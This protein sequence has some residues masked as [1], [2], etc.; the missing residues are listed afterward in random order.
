[1]SPITAP[2][3]TTSLR[4]R[5]NSGTSGVGGS[6]R[7]RADVVTSS[8]ASGAHCAQR[9]RTRS[10]S[11]PVPREQPAYASVIGSSSN[12]SAVTTP[13]LPPPPRSAQNRSG[14]LRASTW[15][16][17]PSAVTRSAAVMRLA[18][19][20][21]AP[22]EEAQAAAERVPDDADV[23]G[24]AVQRREAVLRGG[25]DDG[26]P[27]DSGL[28]ARASR[29]RVDLD[30]VHLRR[31]QQHRILERALRARVVG[32]ALDGDA[33]A[34]RAS[35]ADERLH[36][37]GVARVGDRCGALV[38]GEV[39]AVAR[40]VVARVVGRDGAAQGGG[41]L[42]VCADLNGHDC[43]SALGGLRRRVMGAHCRGL[44]GALQDSEP[45]PGPRQPRGKRTATAHGQGPGH[46]Q[47]SPH[48]SPDPRPPRDGLPRRRIGHACARPAHRQRPAERLRAPRGAAARAGD[49]RRGRRP[50]PRHERAR[51]PVEG[52]QALQGRRA[53]GARWPHRR[54]QAQGP[55]GGRRDRRDPAQ[56]A[57][58]RSPLRDRLRR[59]PGSS[60]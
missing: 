15:I 34:G 46:E 38:D 13:K 27:E 11:C 20:A 16:S 4:P 42:E 22:G 35:R 29:D 7:I 3:M 50:R 56:D 1:M 6:C 23:R 58:R 10:E 9:C 41:M 39:E 57:R 49:G 19:Q 8:V 5:R 33:Q 18:L 36:L 2:S 26:L 37:G 40:A 31:A 54:A 52:P 12:S 14:S 48:R 59:R 53:T 51:V 30:A 43:S 28:H 60:A 25:V 44:A 55:P 45:S 24:R 47:A 21:V 17:S 32:A